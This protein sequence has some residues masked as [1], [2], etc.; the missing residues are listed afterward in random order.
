MKKVSSC[1]KT[2]LKD[3]DRSTSATEVGFKKK[4]ACL[5]CGQKF[6]SK[7]PYNRICDKCGM[8]NERVASS[9]YSVGQRA[10]S[11]SNQFEK[12]LYELN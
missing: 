3:T 8:S 4:R 10:P 5:K 11:S 12:Q 6:H 7:G 1:L 2:N 9:A